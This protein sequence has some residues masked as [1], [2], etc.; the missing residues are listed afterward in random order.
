[1]LNP[2]GVAQY[3][4]KRIAHLHF[5][6]VGCGAIGSN[7]VTALVRQGAREFS[8]VD[9]DRVDR[10]NLSTTAYRAYHIGQTKVSALAQCVEDL[11]Q[12]FDCIVNQYNVELTA[13]TWRR[14]KPLR[15]IPGGNMVVV[16]CVD[17][18]ATRQLL[19]D[20]LG[21]NVL[22]MGI[23]GTYCEAVWG[24]DYKVPPAPAVNEPACNIPYSLN[25]ILMLTGLTVDMLYDYP[26]LRNIRAT[27]KPL[28]AY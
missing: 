25:L 12:N 7:L 5:V 26:D 10:T 28:Q 14:V 3:G 8:L 2:H 16:D 13:Q 22:H 6:V 20:R 19:H 9:F 27:L 15:N 24:Q 18:V 23:G 17:N 4:T 1:M 21:P 11:D